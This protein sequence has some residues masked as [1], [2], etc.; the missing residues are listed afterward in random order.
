MRSHTA[1]LHPIFQAALAPIIPHG[2]HYRT[3]TI[4]M[5]R[6]PPLGFSRGQRVYIRWCREDARGRDIY[7]ISAT[8]E[9]NG[10]S[11]I[12]HA[13]VLENFSTSEV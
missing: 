5:D 12:F 2:R 1:R 9:F 6:D 11:R 10:H 7:V 4:R 8:N 13:R 3:A